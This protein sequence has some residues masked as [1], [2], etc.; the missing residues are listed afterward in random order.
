MKEYKFIS[1]TA[2]PPPRAVLKRMLVDL[3]INER[4]SDLE[5]LDTH[6]YVRMLISD[7]RL[8]KLIAALKR[9][10]FD[11]PW[12]YRVEVE[13]E[14]SDLEP[15]EFAELQIHRAPRGDTGP[16]YDTEYDLST[17]CPECGTGARQ[18]SP[19]RISASALPKKARVCCTHYNEILVDQELA[20]DLMVDL[21]GERGLRQA[22]ERRIRTALPW[23]Q[24]LPDTYMPRADPATG[25]RVDEQCPRCKRD[26]FVGAADQR[27][28]EFTYRLSSRERRALPNFVYTWEHF[29]TSRIKWKPGYVI[30]FASPAILVSNRVMRLFW[31]KRVRGVKFVPVRFLS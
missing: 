19:L 10:P 11:P 22:E 4:N 23:W 31:E 8:E 30:R 25:H 9:L 28:L 5:I 15:A 29:G 14:R 20:T 21:G 7:P 3:G 2:D 6:F 24:V 1:F 18:V 27:P 17:A 16:M 26:G 13:Y 12:D